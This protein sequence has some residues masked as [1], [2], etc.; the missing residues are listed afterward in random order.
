[1]KH[2]TFFEGVAVALAAS[3]VGG[4]SYTALTSVFASGWVLRLL[5]VG[6]S[7]AYVLY[8]LGRSRERVGRMTALAAWAVAALAIWL[9]EPPLLPY[10][11][12][13]L[14]AIWLIRSLYFYSSV[15]SALADLGLTALS[16]AAAIWAATQSGSLL[17]SIWCFFLVQALF[18]FI[19]TRLNRKSEE[20][21]TD[22][23]SE[24]R[25]QG[26]HRAAEA[27]LRKLS[28]IR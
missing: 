2:P 14:S 3:L 21:Q 19:P 4:V 8:L 6:I 1:M 13:H 18:V 22:R 17:V 9:M 12:V 25:F 5:I 11:L 27:A 26:A 23:A 15:L 24:D 10:L 28:S 20:K 16:L 7:L